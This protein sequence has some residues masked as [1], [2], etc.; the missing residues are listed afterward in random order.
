MALTSEESANLM[1]DFDFRGKIKVSAL[2]YADYILN[3]APSTQGHTARIR[4]A[5][6]TFQNPEQAS[7]LLHPP[8]VMDPAIQQSGKDATDQEIQSAVEGVVN[9][10]L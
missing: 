10:F 1:N 4:W 3:E 7:M 8:V 6:S 9:K 5:T 2:R